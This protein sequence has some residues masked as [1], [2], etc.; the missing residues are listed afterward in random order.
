MIEVKYIV[1]KVIIF[2]LIKSMVIIN[3]FVISCFVFIFKMLDLYLRFFVDTVFN[4]LSSFI[5]QSL[6]HLYFCFHFHI[7]MYIIINN[8]MRIIAFS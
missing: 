2:S 6:F 5:F 4:A 3:G 1:L 8:N 7:Y